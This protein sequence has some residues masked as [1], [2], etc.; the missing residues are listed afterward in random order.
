MYR[1]A[2]VS[3]ALLVLVAGC[4]G[5]PAGNGTPTDETPT[6]APTTGPT[7]ESPTT[8]RSPTDGVDL[9]TTNCSDAI[10]WVSFYNLAAAGEYDLW[11]KRQAAVGYTLHGNASVFLVVYSNGKRLGA[12]HVSSVDYETGFHADGHSIQFDEP[13]D[14]R[15]AI[16]VVA[17]RDVD[18]DGT[19]DP[20]T[21]LACEDE[22]GLVST[23]VAVIDF[24]GLTTETPGTSTGT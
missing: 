10:E 21:D 13:L 1:L 12:K 24:D 14:E 15:R 8:E 18:R 9:Q 17:H 7:D 3:L 20:D 2:A 22:N 5:T 16:R 6:D 11:T 23:D 19:F 4:V